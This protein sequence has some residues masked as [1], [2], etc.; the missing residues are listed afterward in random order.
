M[1]N[2]LGDVLDQGS[3]GSCSAFSYLEF[4]R[5]LLAQAGLV[6]NWIDPSEQAQYYE[7]RKMENI[8][9]SED[10]GASLEDALY[11]GEQFGVLPSQS[12]PYTSETFE[13]EPPSKDW[14][15][16]LKLNPKQVQKIN[17]DNVL[18]DI[19]DALNNN[20][21]IYAG[22]TIFGELESEEVANTGILTM[23]N[24]NS[25]EMGGHA[26]V[27][28]GLDNNAKMILVRNSWSKNWGI[29]DQGFEGC[30][31]MPFDY[32]QYCSDAYVG[33]ADEVFV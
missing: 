5:A 12:D 32:V 20:H 29:K 30:F 25:Q 31:W 3:E 21:P 11:V 19:I 1:N 4:R 24:S 28:C 8:A 16:L 33:F 14:D 7:E 9:I 15:V 27:F 26:V 23:P 13:I 22:I 2:L 17:S 6:G 18:S 10:S